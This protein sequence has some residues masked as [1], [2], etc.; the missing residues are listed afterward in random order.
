MNIEEFYNKNYK[1]LMIIPLAILIVSLLVIYLH[2]SKTND[3]FD[4]DVSLKGGISAT[5]PTENPVNVDELQN[6][7]ASKFND[8]TVRRLSEF[9]SNKQTGILIEVPEI[10]ENE[11]KTTLEEYL[12]IK[13]TNENYSVEITGSS[14][15]SSF[16]SQMLK[17][18]LFAFILMALSI[19]ITFR[20][21][22]PS[23]AV[24]FSAFTDIVATIAIV[25][26]FDA[27]ISSAGISAFLLL[28]GYSVDTDILQTTKMMKR[29]EGT[30][31]QRFVSA[32]KTGLTMTITS[33]AA[34]T[35]GY[36]LTDSEAIKQMFIIIAIGLLIDPITTYLMNAGLIKWYMERKHDKAS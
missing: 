20:S 35:V 10:D 17:A 8:A 15:G 33:L 2:Y 21:F 19:L 13:L 28:I 31:W 25:N 22:I 5:I 27:R 4:R 23:L 7:L 16:Y 36:F 30:L 9:G 24:V 34:V 11:L 29:T 18:M 12:N 1:R 6:L 3:F 14:L 26:L 32:M